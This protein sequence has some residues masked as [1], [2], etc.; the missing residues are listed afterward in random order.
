MS[1]SARSI[2]AAAG[3]LNSSPTAGARPRGRKVGAKP[4][5]AVSSATWAAANHLAATTGGTMKPRSAMS[6]AGTSKS[7]KGNL[8]KRSL[9][10]THAAT[11]PGTVT[12]SQP[13]CGGVAAPAPCLR[14]KYCGVHAAG[15]GPDTISLPAGAYRLTIGGIDENGV[16]VGPGEIGEIVGWSGAI[17]NGYHNQAAAIAPS[18]ALPP[19]AIMRSPACAACGCD[20]AT[21]LRANTGRRGVV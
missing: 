19:A 8:P 3:S 1:A 5:C 20:V 21:T 15:A 13:R 14:R 12:L 2:R 6:I 11:A 16:E 10:A 7:A 9:K 18:T 4:G 17:M